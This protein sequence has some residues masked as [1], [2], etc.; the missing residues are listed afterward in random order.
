MAWRKWGAKWL[1]AV[2]PN[3][4]RLN[5]L[6]GWVPGLIE[7]AP[8]GAGPGPPVH[9]VE[10]GELAVLEARAVRVCRVEATAHRA[11]LLQHRWGQKKPFFILKFLMPFWK[12]MVASMCWALRAASASLRRFSSLAAST[13]AFISMALDNY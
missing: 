11:H 10:A 6:N 2:L 5:L 13:C 3:W 7:A 1:G 8:D 4:S 9:A 12:R